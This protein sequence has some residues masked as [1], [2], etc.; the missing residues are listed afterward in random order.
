MVLGPKAP[1]LWHW[2]I[3]VPGALGLLQV[4]VVYNGVGG[5]GVA[6][7]VREIGFEGVW[8]RSGSDGGFRGWWASRGP[9]GA[10]GGGPLPGI[11]GWLWFSCG[12]ARCGKGL[13]AIFQAF[14]VSACKTFILTGTR[15]SFYEV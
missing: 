13:V 9:V 1:L 8:G 15:L 11:W 7:I 3:I 5:L 6:A 12:I 4:L 14:F 2:V 10:S